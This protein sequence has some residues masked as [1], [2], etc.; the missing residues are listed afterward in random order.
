M[1][2]MENELMDAGFVA[3]FHVSKVHADY[4]RKLT[5][6]RNDN[7]VYRTLNF[8][9]FCLGRI[10]KLPSDHSGMWGRSHIAS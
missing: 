4:K 7:V 3:V 9:V 1:G 5:H 8:V 10:K 2:W 6:T